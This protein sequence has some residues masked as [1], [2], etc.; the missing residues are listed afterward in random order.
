MM[1]LMQLYTMPR[2]MK[3]VWDTTFWPYMVYC[4]CQRRAFS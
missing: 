2:R 1:G 4:S 3:K